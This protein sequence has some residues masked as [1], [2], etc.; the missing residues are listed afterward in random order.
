MYS[1]ANKILQGQRDPEDVVQASL[2]KLIEKVGLLRSMD[3]RHRVN[4]MI[5]AVKHTAISALR[6]LKPDKFNSLDDEDWAEGR[7]L[8]ADGSL[9][10]T[11]FRREN[12]GRMESV[13]CL[14]DGRSKYLLQA[15]YF[16]DMDQDDIAKEL[17]IK[18]DS[19]R[20]EMSRARKKVRV[21]LAE[22]YDMVD[23]W[24]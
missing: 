14:L 16:L 4:Y 2:V 8:H 6:E 12:V 20:M 22:K 21:L 24:T 19:V 9:E 18:P 7:Q 11:I 3:E 5:T 1:E 15:R 17:H 23:L 10:E 13:W